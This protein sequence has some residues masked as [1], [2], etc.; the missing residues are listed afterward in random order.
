M[1]WAWSNPVRVVGDCSAPGAVAEAVAGRRAVLIATEGAARR[2]MVE[3]LQRALGFGTS[4]AWTGVLVNP[5]LVSVEQAVRDLE[6]CDAAVIVGIGGGSALDSAKAIGLGLRSGTDAVR[7]AIGGDTVPGGASLP[8]V[9]VPTTA[10]TGSEVTP[11]ATLW[12]DE[13]SRKLSI[14]GPGLYSEVACLDAELTISAPHDVTV[15]A[16][17]DAISQACEALWNRHATVVTDGFA[18]RSLQLGMRALPRVAASPTDFDERRAMLQASLLAGMA[19]AHTRTALAHS[20]SY[21]L[22][23]HY[24]LPHGIAASFS[25]PAVLQ[26]VA[27]TAGP[28]L[29]YVATALGFPSIDAMRAA[30]ERLLRELEVGKHMRLHGIGLQEV[31]GLGEE[32]L[33]PGRSDNLV[34]DVTVSDAVA[35]ATRALGVLGS[36]G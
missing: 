4:V 34:R 12:D 23:A 25:L 30:L 32:F 16:G 20:I 13:S 7:R 29:A 28:R 22:T 27:E 31:V 10:G 5:T 26:F 3:R 15:S 11:F 9:A 18:I 35:I 36:S 6:G 2:G 14:A 33:T 17:L 21:P 1:T 8:M 24:G 19:I